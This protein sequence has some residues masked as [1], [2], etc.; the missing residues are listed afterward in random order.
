MAH[1]GLTKTSKKPNIKHVLPSQLNLEERKSLRKSV[2]KIFLGGENISYLG[3]AF[4]GVLQHP[5]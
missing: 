5:V 2:E 3:G 4:L 1:T